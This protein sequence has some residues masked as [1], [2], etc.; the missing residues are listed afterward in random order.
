MQKR[1][2]EWWKTIINDIDY[3][4]LPYYVN[5]EYYY[6]NAFYNNI[7]IFIFLIDYN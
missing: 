6:M 2:D 7:T 3:Y 1:F 4:F 5:V